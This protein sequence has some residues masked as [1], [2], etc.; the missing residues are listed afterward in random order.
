MNGVRT[1]EVLL[2]GNRHHGDSVMCGRY[3]S[4]DD[5]YGRNRQ[6]FFPILLPFSR[7]SLE[8]FLNYVEQ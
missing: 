2:F 5:F 6:T 7:T 8:P 1:E 3:T 4:L